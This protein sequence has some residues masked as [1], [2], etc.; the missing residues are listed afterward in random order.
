MD[1]NKCEFDPRSNEI[2]A[3]FHEI[4]PQMY[5]ETF[6]ELLDCA[7]VLHRQKNIT[8]YQQIEAKLLKIQESVFEKLNA[9]IAEVFVEELTDKTDAKIAMLERLQKDLC[10]YKDFV[11]A[12]LLLKIHEGKL[13]QYPIPITINLQI[14][15][16]NKEKEVSNLIKVAYDEHKAKFQGHVEF[17]KNGV[18]QLIDKNRVKIESAKVEKWKTIVEKPILTNNN[19]L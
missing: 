1:S 18:N 12:R 8:L 16:N 17:I 19:S 4:T 14:I 10:K 11:E 15:L 7:I 9:G 2:L 3:R 5:L 13:L 6:P